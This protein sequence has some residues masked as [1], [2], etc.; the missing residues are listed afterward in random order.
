MK[1][2]FLSLILA[3]T[4]VAHADNL[5]TDNREILTHCNFMAQFAAIYAEARHKGMTGAELANEIKELQEDKDFP[6]DIKKEIAT[7][8]IIGFKAGGE[9]DDPRKIGELTMQAC[10]NYHRERLGK[11]K[12]E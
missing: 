12:L 7:A 5:P 11:P 9:I 8:I 3:L 4:A 10:V 1:K 2:L 6:D